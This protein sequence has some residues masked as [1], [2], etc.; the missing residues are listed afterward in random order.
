MGGAGRSGK[1]TVIDTRGNGTLGLTVRDGGEVTASGSKDTTYSIAVYGGT[2]KFTGGH[3]NAKMCGL[4]NGVKLTD[5][6]PEGYAYRRYDG[7]G[8]EFSKNS[9]VS[10]ADAENRT[11][12]AAAGR[13]DLAVMKCEHAGMDAEGNCPYC[14]LKIAAAITKPGIFRGYTDINEAIS[15]AQSEENYG[16]ALTLCR[17]EV[18]SLTLSKG[19]LAL[20]IRG[21]AVDY[22]TISG[23]DVT[24]DRNM[25]AWVTFTGGKLSITGG[26]FTNYVRL[27]SSEA[28]ISG[29]Q[30]A[31]I[32]M[33]ENSKV[34]TLA[35]YLGEG[36]AFADKDSGE[37]VNGYVTGLKNVTVNAGSKADKAIEII[38]KVAL[39]RKPRR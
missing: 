31:D 4:Y 27:K 12:W 17:G 37:I 25:D 28:R 24:I 23:A 15:D 32:D 20:E 2:L 36:R 35:G 21:A 16:C 18:R 26:I 33:T 39:V 34:S 5:L 11:G 29:G 13:Y 9:W 8:T 14:G 22:C 10:H 38:C 19:R 30:F 3:I 7:I 1:L 6:L